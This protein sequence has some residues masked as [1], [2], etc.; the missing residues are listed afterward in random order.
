MS[1]SCF[2]SFNLHVPGL[3]LSS[4]RYHVPGLDLSQNLGS[5]QPLD[6]E[7]TFCPF[8]A[9]FSFWNSMMFIF[10]CLRLSH[11]SHRLSSLF[12]TSLF[13]L[14]PWVGKI[15][16]R[17]ERLLQYSGLENSMNCTVHGVAKSQTQLS[18]LHFLFV[19]S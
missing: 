1:W 2:W 17:R 7:L 18:N 11:N 12:F 4:S 15:P 9:L 6:F 5:L 8:L 3:D 14:V 19:T 16:W 13:L 10:I